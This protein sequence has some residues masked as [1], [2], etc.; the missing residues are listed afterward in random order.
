MTHRIEFKPS[1]RK[2]FLDLPADK[3]KRLAKAIDKLAE[4]PRPAG[5][6]KMAG[7]ANDYRIRVGDYRII[8]EVQDEILLIMVLKIA[9]RREVYR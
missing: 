5:V 2:E 9:H 7:S 8:Y 6:E 1:A 4:T 3:Q